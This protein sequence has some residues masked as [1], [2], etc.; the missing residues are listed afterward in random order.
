MKTFRRC[1]APAAVLTAAAL[2][3]PS[4]LADYYVAQSLDG[5]GS[6]W[7]FGIK[8]A[9]QVDGTFT[10]SFTKDNNGTAYFTF[11]DYAA[12]GWN[13][14]GKRFGNP[15][16]EEIVDLDKKYPVGENSYCYKFTQQGA[17]T[18]TFNYDSNDSSNS[19]VIF[20]KVS[21]PNPDP[22][23]NP[24]PIELPENGYYVFFVKPD[25]W[26]T[27]KVWAWNTRNNSEK[28]TV[29]E[30]YPGDEMIQY[31]GNTYVWIAPQGKTP[32]M[33]IFSNGSNQNEKAGNGNLTYVNKAT[34]TSSGSYTGGDIPPV[35]PIPTEGAGAVTDWVSDGKTVTVTC[36]NANLYITP[37]SAHV[38][39]V[40]TLPKNSTA[41]ERRSITVNATP[42]A[43][44][45]INEKDATLTITMKDGIN[46][47][48]N[49]ETG[50][51][52]FIEGAIAEADTDNPTLAEA[53]YLNNSTGTRTVSFRP[54]G[55]EA[56]YGGGY[57]GKWG[58][59]DGQTLTMNNTQTGGWGADSWEYPHCITIPFVV[60]TKG[61]GV[62]FDD[63]WRGAVMKPSSTNGLSYSSGSQN[64]ISYYY[65]G[66]GNLDEVIANYTSLTG[67]QGLPPYWALGYI[68]SR[69]GYWSKGEA[70]GIIQGI[71][72]A[73]IPLDGI[74]FDI[75][76][77]G[78][79]VFAMGNLDWGSKFPNPSDMLKGWKDQ[80][81]HTTCI[82]EPFF[83]SRCNN[84]NYLTTGDAKEKSFLADTH[85]SG[86]SNMSWL[87]SDHVG[88]LDTTNPAA[89]DWM[90][91]FYKA[92]TAEGVDGWWLD[93]GEPE[94]HDDDSS[95]KG[96]SVSQVHNEF[97]QLWIERVY[98]GLSKEFPDMRPFIMPRSGTSGMQRFS[99]FPWTGDINRNWG[100]LQAQIPSLINMS[101]SGV[102]Y[103]GSDIGGFTSTGTNPSLYL[104]W[105]EFGALSPMLRT[106]SPDRPEPTNSEYDDIRD[107][108][109]NYIN[110][111]YRL[112]P[113]TYTLSYENSAFGYPMARPACAYDNYK[114]TL[115][116]SKDSY[117]WGRDIF[118]APVVENTS[119]RSITFPEGE[120]LDLYAAMM[121]ENETPGI[122]KGS[123]TYSAYSAPLE[124]LPFFLR[125]G[126][127][128][129]TFTQKDGFKNTTE[130]KYNDITVYHFMNHEKGAT[131]NNR[132]RYN[133]KI[134][135]DD[136]T[137]PSSLEDG[138]YSI[139]NIDAITY[140]EN[141]DN[142]G[143]YLI[144]VTP[145]EK[146][147]A[148]C[149]GEEIT[150]HF[151][152]YGC[153]FY[154][155]DGMNIRGPENE[156]VTRAL[157]AL[158]EDEKQPD[159]TL[160]GSLEEAQKN[161]GDA[162]YFDKNNE[163]VY[164]KVTRPANSTGYTIGFGD[165]STSVEELEIAG[166]LHLEYCDGMLN[167]S[168]PERY[169]SACIELF[170]ADG[171]ALGVIDGLTADGIV[172]STEC[173]AAE[174]FCI[175][176]I[177]AS[178]KYGQK[179]SAT[180]KFFVR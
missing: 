23:P 163:Y 136:R 155:F 31:N 141:K 13:Q 2:T 18:I 37:Y 64:P 151:H 148:Y 52:S 94:A 150:F 83:T 161:P 142:H 16:G 42:D 132:S 179:K 134:Y 27:P 119:S 33:I 63:H 79:G 8:M 138:N 34:Y 105:V 157:N 54:A 143:Q 170:T 177:T 160:T 96:G 135:M 41:E 116:E 137:S 152:I 3:P 153:E 25:N 108:V 62:L 117:L 97:G 140:D 19:Y 109:R 75:Y 68:T 29:A 146:T 70:D 168:V 171:K 173:P 169:E 112:L 30:A 149:G 82:T 159:I 39:K 104:R 44:F 6:T 85:V 50:L 167:Y 139:I 61:Y 73:Q 22:N 45:D 128:L 9:E 17:F 147:S 107:N 113:Y 100:G 154:D 123:T 60:S 114:P 122:Y 10:H 40:F 91:D 158:A 178:G 14:S 69:F 7:D 115:A 172:H 110:L 121:T 102:S 87:Q 165:L 95:H 88:L 74:V 24:G 53:K 131:G 5:A 15:D 1:A 28:C 51:I 99:T 11:F 118:V 166:A 71:R 58:S 92:R 86:N 57:N 48:V 47:L 32:D 126:G 76:W 80:G 101:M 49:K 67:R 84:W 55:D 26:T 133:G 127:I 4:A 174:G 93:L 176:R 125:K 145:D 66:G 59:V 144:K 46:V 56:F 106:H 98:N 175:A 77:Q 111:R 38:V 90:W 78:D 164:L 36:E 12:T 103:I 35:P 162:V 43:Q 20:T 156:S 130:L 180:A 65:I 81:I 129:P 72:D 21:D 89:L 120:W 124:R